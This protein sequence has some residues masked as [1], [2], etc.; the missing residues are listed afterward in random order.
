MMAVFMTVMG[1]G[2]QAQD[3]ESFKILENE[4]HSTIGNYVDLAMDLVQFGYDNNSAIS[5]VQAAAIF[6]AVPVKPL[7]LTESPQG[8]EVEVASE[9]SYDPQVLMAD[10]KKM[11]QD[12]KDL[13]AYITSMEGKIIRQ[14]AT[15]GESS[16]D[17]DHAT[18]Y[19]GSGDSRTVYL[20]APSD[21]G[22]YC[23]KARGDGTNLRMSVTTDRGGD[24]KGSSEGTTP[25]ITFWIG[26]AQKIRINVTNNGYR[27]NTCTVV[28]EE[29]TNPD[30]MAKQA[31]TV[32]NILDALFGN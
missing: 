20:Y 17:V 27:T 8:K 11:A 1:L 10:A 16:V 5:L 28:L 31:E 23:V 9:Y 22:K 30:K 24:Y 12:D 3:K 32:V 29:M 18:I 6:T 2:V 25:S 21:G 19:I 26:L 7:A 13:L 15:R 4:E 14:T